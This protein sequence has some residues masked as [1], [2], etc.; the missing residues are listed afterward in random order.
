MPQKKSLSPSEEAVKFIPLRHNIQLPSWLA[1]EPCKRHKKRTC[2]N[3]IQER[4]LNSELFDIWIENSK[5]KY[6]IFIFEWLSSFGK[7]KT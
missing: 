2:Q 4:E 3:N 6:E 7:I 1:S 5:Q